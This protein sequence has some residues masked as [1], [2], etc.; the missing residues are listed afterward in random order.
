MFLFFTPLIWEVLNDK[1]GDSHITRSFLKKWEVS[2]K[3]VD[4]MVRVIIALCIS[5]INYLFYQIAPWKTILLCGA[6]H[7]LLFDYVIAYILIKRGIIKG[8]W[9]SYMGSKG[10]DNVGWWKNL[11]PNLKLVARIIIFVIAFLIYFN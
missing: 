5:L 10:I 3:K 8:N 9:Y 2:S 1:D 6:I 11:N 4:V 7:F